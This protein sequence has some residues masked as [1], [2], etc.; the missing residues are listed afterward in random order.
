MTS[1]KEAIENFGRSSQTLG[2]RNSRSGYEQFIVGMMFGLAALDVLMVVA[3]GYAGSWLLGQ[4]V[5]D[6]AL[7]GRDQYSVLITL[8]GLA[9]PL[10]IFVFGGYHVGGLAQDYRIVTTALV[11]W[12][13]LFAAALVLTVMFKVSAQFSR[14][15]M[16]TWY[17]SACFGFLGLRGLLVYCRRWLLSQGV[18]VRRVALIG[19]ATHARSVIAQV[20]ERVGEEVVFVA[21]FGPASRVAGLSSSGTAEQAVSKLN[22]DFVD[23]VDEV[24]V[25][26]SPSTDTVLQHLFYSSH[27]ELFDVCFIPNLD[28][29]T[30]LSDAI[31]HVGTQVVIG[32]SPQ[33]ARGLRGLFKL[34]FDRCCAALGV[35]ALSPILIMI[36][37]AVR[38]DS[39]G[40]IFFRQNRHGVNGRIFS[41]IKFRTLRYAPEATRMRQ[42]RPNDPRFTRVGEFL[43]RW[44]L[45]ELPQLLNVIRGEMS[46]V[47]PRPHES[48]MNQ[49]AADLDS[50]Y[51][52]RHR[53]LPGMTGL[54]Q[55]NGHRGP[56]RSSEQMKR[57]LEFDLWYIE[58]W[59]IALDMRILLRTI[60]LVFQ[61]PA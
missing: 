35:I 2:R 10:C 59:S 3:T 36:A 5:H 41:I 18:G 31:Q 17:L 49:A 40:P 26:Q 60:I 42:V 28:G 34:V 48:S 24:W 11:G 56:V 14:L 8:V 16:G 50:S 23:A 47:G 33:P 55:I 44:S 30:V 1:H 45:D 25:L 53:V 51:R 57:R 37:I 6:H 54:A 39:P 12:S 27:L 22:K 58:H 9:S 20:S 7:L 38:L 15:W 43:R 52:L 4:F 29:Y 46:L 61:K 32:L 13:L 19:E 21:Y